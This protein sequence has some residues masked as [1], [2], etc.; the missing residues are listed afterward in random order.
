MTRKYPRMNKDS[1]YHKVNEI[2]NGS[3]KNKNR[4]YIKGI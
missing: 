4:L 3:G 1:C 2:L